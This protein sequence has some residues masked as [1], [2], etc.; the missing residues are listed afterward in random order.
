MTVIAATEQQLIFETKALIL[1]TIA[2]DDRGINDRSY[3]EA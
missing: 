2:G 1:F 3:Q